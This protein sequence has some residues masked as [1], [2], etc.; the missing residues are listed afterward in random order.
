MAFPLNPV[1]G[2]IYNSRIYCSITNLWNIIKGDTMLEVAHW[3]Q[4]PTTST[5]GTTELVKYIKVLTFSKPLISIDNKTCSVFD[6]QRVNN[7]G[8]YTYP[9]TFLNETQ[10]NICLQKLHI[11]SI[12]DRVV[13]VYYEAPRGFVGE[14][15]IYASV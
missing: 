8:G 6:C 15:M 12:V 11:I 13:T 3:T 7:G 14:F 1:D 9:I 2:Q 10:T 5:M 4:L